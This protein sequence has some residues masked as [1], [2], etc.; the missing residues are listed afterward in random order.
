MY[1][2]DEL[3]TEPTTVTMNSCTL[4]DHCITNSPD[5]IA[6]SGVVHLAISDHALIHMTYKAKCERSRARIIKTR[7]MKNFHKSSY[8]RDLQQKAWSDIETLNDPKMTYGPCGRI[9]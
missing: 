4:I 7:Q 6:K 3:I 9:C 2:L 5:K 1:G 8:L